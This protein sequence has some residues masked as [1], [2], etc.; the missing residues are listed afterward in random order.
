M[1]YNVSLL[2]GPKTR[3]QFGLALENKCFM[4]FLKR[5]IMCSTG[6]RSETQRSTCQ[7][8]VGVKKHHQK[9]WI[10]AQSLTKIED[11]K[12]KKDTVN[13]SR[14]RVAK[15]KAQEEY[16]EAHRVV[17]RSSRKDK[18]EYVD[19]LAAEAEQAAAT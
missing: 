11:R 6:G 14:T 12:R 4:T 5:K 15:A 7:E 19:R 2:K 3:E 8:V 1:K 13:N 9:E 17:K 16:P 10:T 18:K